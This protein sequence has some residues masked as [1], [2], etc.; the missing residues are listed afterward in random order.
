M[1]ILK[2]ISI[3]LTAALVL[4]ACSNNSSMMDDLNSTGNS[5]VRF[6]N[7]TF[8][9]QLYNTNVKSVYDATELAINNTNNYNIESNTITERNA[10][11]KGFIKTEKSMFDKEGKTPYSIEITK[12]DN[13][14]VNIYIKI[15]TVGDKQ[16]SVDLLSSI[17]TN[18]GL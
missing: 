12:Y 6:A 18:L 14:T 3:G 8:S 5:I 17:R 7:G 2:T 4:S 13:S 15:G 1:K 10:K 11:I 16:S 9:A